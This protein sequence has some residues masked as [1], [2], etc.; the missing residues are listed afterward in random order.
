MKPRAN[1]GA[2]R[3]PPRLR[4]RLRPASAGAWFWE[5]SLERLSGCWGTRNLGELR[6][7]SPHGA[8]VALGLTKK[9]PRPEWATVPCT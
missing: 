9:S 7:A 1:Q 8:C 6:E 5:A 2:L 3:A 4:L